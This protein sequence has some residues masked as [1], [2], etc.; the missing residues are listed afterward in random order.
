MTTATVTVDGFKITV[1]GLIP[2]DYTVEYT[3]TVDETLYN[4][5][6]NR[7]A[8]RVL[9]ANSTISAV[10]QTV[11]YDGDVV[12][13]A[14]GENCTGVNAS[15]VVVKDANGDVVTTATVTVDGFK[16]TIRGLNVGNYTV[17][18]INT[19]DETLYNTAS[20]VTGAKVT[21]A[22]STVNGT[23][24]TVPYSH[25]NIVTVASENATSVTYNVTN[26]AGEVVAEGTINGNGTFT[27]SDLPVGEYTVNYVT[28][29][30]GNHY[31]V[32]NTSKIT[33]RK[34]D[35]I[36][37]LPEVINYTG[38][39]V[40]IIVNVTDE[41]GNAVNEGS[42]TLIID[43]GTKLS[44][45]LMA[46]AESHTEKVIDGKATFKDI[47]LGDP[48]TYPSLAEFDE[49]EHYNA[50]D[51]KSDVVVLP[52]N[53]TTES[54]DV[55]GSSGDKV[56]IVA[57]IVD[58][59]GNP[60]QNGTAVLKLNGKEYKA[61]VKDGKATFKGVELP[62]E[63]TQA[64]IDYLG[65][66][67]YNPSKTTIQITINE[68]PEPEPEP[69]PEP[70]NP[71]TEKSVPVIPAAGNPIALVVIALLTLVSTVSLG[72]KK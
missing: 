56:D 72:R 3:N 16:I 22:P 62:S 38:A 52:L 70:V 47:T 34:L 32:T 44:D 65:N 5:A 67:Y 10:E 68:E 4:T 49:T 66:D 51:D 35:V 33:V 14:S 30:D 42:V 7:T 8:A 69:Q 43:W 29:V 64:T 17:E 40:D 41:F 12:L 31:S 13:V 1:S 61:E 11:V 58:Q 26:A 46:T 36:V 25:S 18:Y 6:S 71:V 39:V 45:K 28:E 53:T 63:S 50:G 48:G 21:P 37:S 59:N 27:V 23:D 57:D 54:D 9:K 55:S 60:V 19:V 20:N 2:G 15:S 24:V